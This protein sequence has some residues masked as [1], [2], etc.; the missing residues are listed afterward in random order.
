MSDSNTY[1][2]T[3]DVTIIITAHYNSTA[4]F[5]GAVEYVA[6]NLFTSAECLAGVMCGRKEYTKFF[7]LV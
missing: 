3:L 7:T 2:E 4:L 1:Y 5:T 6:D